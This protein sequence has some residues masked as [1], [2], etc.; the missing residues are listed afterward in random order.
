MHTPNHTL[1][2]NNTL[3]FL[4]IILIISSCGQSIPE[5]KGVDLEQ[6]KIDRGA[7]M[8]EREKMMNAIIDQKNSLLKLDEWQIAKFLGKPDENE[9][10][11]R[12]QKIYRYFL[13]PAK[14][15]ANQ[16]DEPVKLVIRF[17]AMGL[18]KEVSIE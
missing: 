6:W 9:L 16:P 14:S 10:L 18:A 8:G 7:C 15:C 11:K 3:L 13:T 17:N 4:F 1:L 12:N 2:Y 5:L